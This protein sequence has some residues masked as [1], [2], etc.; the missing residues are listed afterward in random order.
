MSELGKLVAQAAADRE[1]AEVEHKTLEAAIT[2]TAMREHLTDI[3][4]AAYAIQFDGNYAIVND[5]EYVLVRRQDG[6]Y[7]QVRRCRTCSEF[8][9][10]G[11][12]ERQVLG[13]ADLRADERSDEECLS[14]RERRRVS[15]EAAESAPCVW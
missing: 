11:N 8:V 6:A 2:E 14:C 1:K 9:Y 7:Y 5:H 15:G 4:R 10:D 13:I 12:R 3:V